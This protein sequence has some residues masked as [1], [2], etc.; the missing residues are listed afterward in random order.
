VAVNEYL[1]IVASENFILFCLSIDGD[2]ERLVLCAL[3][4]FGA[5]TSSCDKTID[6]PATEKNDINTDSQSYGSPLQQEKY[7]E[8]EK[9]APIPNFR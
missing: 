7:P 6:F 1:E 2:C 3:Y 8:R 9:S 4:M 5:S